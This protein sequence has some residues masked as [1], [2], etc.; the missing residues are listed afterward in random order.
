M[1]KSS[2]AINMSSNHSASGVTMTREEIRRKKALDQKFKHQQKVAREKQW[3]ADHPEIALARQ[4][5]KEEEAQRRNQERLE[6]VELE[7]KL[8]SQQAKKKASNKFAALLADSSDEEQDAEPVEA[9]PEEQVKE[10]I[11]EPEVEKPK[12]KPLSLY[13]TNAKFSWADECDSDNENA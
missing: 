10:E 8:T 13:S 11:K 9:Q 3:L 7:K 1:Y 12:Q 5:E 2:S 4:R 6:R